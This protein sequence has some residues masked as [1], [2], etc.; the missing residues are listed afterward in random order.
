MFLT[1]IMG[2]TMVTGDGLGKFEIFLTIFFS[3]LI[4][5][6]T[7]WGVY[8]LESERSER[9][10]IETKK[11]CYYRSRSSGMGFGFNSGG[12]SLIPFSGSTKVY[13]DCG[14]TDLYPD[15]MEE[16]RCVKY[17]D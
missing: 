10:C 2:M 6:F 8:T 4:I 16:T 17:K 11:Y 15:I 5:L 7:V 14:K 13:V 1:L 12:G 3:L 9:V